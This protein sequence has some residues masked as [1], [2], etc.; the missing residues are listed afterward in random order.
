MKQLFCPG[1]LT[2]KL[3]YNYQ[4]RGG[5]WSVCVTC[6]CT[7]MLIITPGIIQPAP[8]SVTLHHRGQQQCNIKLQSFLTLVL[9]GLIN[10]LRMS[11]CPGKAQR[12]F[13]LPLR[14]SDTVA[15]HKLFWVYSK[16]SSACSGCSIMGLCVSC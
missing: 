14:Y 9:S 11:S 8:L 15:Y 6:Q 5:K 2:R 13:E 7:R 1:T 3:P 10:T 12:F 4:T 16:L